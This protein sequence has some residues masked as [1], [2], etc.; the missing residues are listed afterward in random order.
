[1]LFS[2]RIRT[3][4][5]G[6]NMYVYYFC[7]FFFIVRI[8]PSWKNPPAFEKSYNEPWSRWC[9]CCR[10]QCRHSWIFNSR[11]EY[12]KKKTIHIDKLFSI[13]KVSHILCNRLQIYE[14]HSCVYMLPP[15]CIFIFSLL[16]IHVN[17]FFLCVFVC[18]WCVMF[19][20]FRIVFWKYSEFFLFLCYW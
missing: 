13:P 8:V 1:M 9:N 6:W 18:I 11:S 15:F 5:S 10:L 17:V 12:L 19:L 7:C 20:L 16:F 14:I 3:F 2:F 4:V